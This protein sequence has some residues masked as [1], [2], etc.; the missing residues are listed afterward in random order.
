MITSYYRFYFIW[1]YIQEL[2]E[3]AGKLSVNGY[4]GIQ[5]RDN[6]VSGDLDLYGVS[7]STFNKELFWE[8]TLMLLNPYLAVKVLYKDDS[9]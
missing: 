8:P 5:W 4:F 2:D 7:S 1:Q 6:T 9:V 3:V